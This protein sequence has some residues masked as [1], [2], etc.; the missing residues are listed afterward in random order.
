MDKKEKEKVIKAIES[1]IESIKEEKKKRYSENLNNEYEKLRK[2]LGGLKRG[3]ILT[4]YKKFKTFSLVGLAVILIS[5]IFTITNLTFS[6]NLGKILFHISEGLW[7]QLF[8]LGLSIFTISYIFY[9]IAEANKDRGRLMLA[10]MHIK[11]LGEI[12]AIKKREQDIQK[13]LR[14]IDKLDSLKSVSE[15]ETTKDEDLK[16]M[17]D[18]IYVNAL[19]TKLKSLRKK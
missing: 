5:I 19:E 8:Y 11:R 16:F 2:E 17:Y 4:K 12:D 18:Q 13:M 7:N 15:I 6:F 1:K 14:A 3:F 10:E 9:Q